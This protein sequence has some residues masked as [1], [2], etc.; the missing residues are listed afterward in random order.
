MSRKGTRGNTP[1][2]LTRIS[3]LPNAA[4]VASTKAPGIAAA[5]ISPGT[6]TALRPAARMDAATSSAARLVVQIVDGE[7]RAFPC[8]GNGNRFANPPAARP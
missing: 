7:I 2:L 3:I 4:T 6:S 8:Q 5:E 1:A